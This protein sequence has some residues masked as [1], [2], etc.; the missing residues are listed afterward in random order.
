MALADG[1]SEETVDLL[2]PIYES[3]EDRNATED[4]KR[5]ARLLNAAMANRTENRTIEA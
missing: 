3:F 2:R 1:D 4:L 5:S